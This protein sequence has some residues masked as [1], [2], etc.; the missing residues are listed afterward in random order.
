MPITGSP[1]PTAPPQGPQWVTCHGRRVVVVV[2]ADEFEAAGWGAS[3]KDVLRSAPDMGPLDIE[4]SSEP[5]PEV[6]RS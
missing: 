5:A 3:F 2:A 1:C 6:S 4:R